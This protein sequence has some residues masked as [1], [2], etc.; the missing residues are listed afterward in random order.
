MRGS[1]YRF[2]DSVSIF[3]DFFF[4]SVVTLV[5]MNILR[6]FYFSVLMLLRHVVCSSFIME[7]EISL[8]SGFLRYSGSFV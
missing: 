4:H 3:C 8:V 1:A 5:P 2:F 6:V 7:A